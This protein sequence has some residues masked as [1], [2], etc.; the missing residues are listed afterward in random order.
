[1]PVAR[2]VEVLT[3]RPPQVSRTIPAETG[4]AIVE[5]VGEWCGKVQVGQR[6]RGFGCRNSP[7]EQAAKGRCHAHHIATMRRQAKARDAHSSEVI[8]PINQI[9][10]IV[11]ECLNS[12]HGQKRALVQGPKL[13][14]VGIV[15]ADELAAIFGA[16]M[17]ARMITTR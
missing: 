12:V 17:R 13:K 16:T 9:E 7:I 14:A 8:Q 4:R 11:R 1:M 10:K 2:P 5:P 3:L 6:P 15:L